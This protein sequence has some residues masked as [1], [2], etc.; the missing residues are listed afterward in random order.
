[1]AGFVFFVQMFAWVFGFSNGVDWIDLWIRT[2]VVVTDLDINRIET[3]DFNRCL[4]LL[5]IYY[6]PTLT[7][8][9]PALIID[10]FL[11]VR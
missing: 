4:R 10:K 1:M 3:A 8:E 7:H 9:F 6:N 5:V 11:L 2:L